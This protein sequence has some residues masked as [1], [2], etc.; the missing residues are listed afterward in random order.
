MVWGWLHAAGIQH[1]SI[2]CIHKPPSESTSCSCCCCCLYTSYA[3]ELIRSH[4]QADAISATRHSSVWSL[5]DIF[6]DVE[7]ADALRCS[8]LHIAA[9]GNAAR[10]KISRK[11]DSIDMLLSAV[12]AAGFAC[13]LANDSVVTRCS[14]L[15]GNLLVV[16]THTNEIHEEVHSYKCL[17]CCIVDMAYCATLNKAGTVTL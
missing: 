3:Y 13:Y 4:L 9:Q 14:M 10:Y 5:F 15:A 8:L 12:A 17:D 16:S 6:Y 2:L 11:H 7:S 1:R